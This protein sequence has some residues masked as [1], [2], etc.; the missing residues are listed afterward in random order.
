MI[1]DKR[2]KELASF[3][4]VD[5]YP[6]LVATQADHIKRLQEQVAYYRD[7]PLA[8]DL[9]RKERAFVNPKPRFA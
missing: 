3:Y 4:Q 1:N 5:N 8:A 9:E 2:A 6:E 7:N